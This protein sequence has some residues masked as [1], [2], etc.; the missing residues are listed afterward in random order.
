MAEN[1]KKVLLV[2]AGL[3]VAVGAALLYYLATKKPGLE[4]ISIFEELKLQGLL[5]VKRNSGE[6]DIKYFLELL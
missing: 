6:L 1:K 4:M 5:E 2:L 3:G